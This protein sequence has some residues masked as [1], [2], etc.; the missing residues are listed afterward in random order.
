MDGK[1]SDARPAWMPVVA[2]ALQRGDGRWL[3]HRRAPGKVHAGLWEFPGGKV[4]AFETPAQALVRELREELGIVCD[5]QAMAPVA[6]AETRNQAAAREI[7]ILLYT[8]TR[9]RG[10]PQALEGGA[11][12]WLTPAEVRA[13]PK[14]ELDEML[15][16]QLFLK[17]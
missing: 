16:A 9:W 13:L 11:V 6:F 4:E 17:R 12:A 10:D 14:P 1:K 8:I 2:G 3:M 7:V 15:A 5:P